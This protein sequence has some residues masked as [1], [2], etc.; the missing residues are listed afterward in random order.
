MTA[1]L[2]LIA[3]TMGDPAGIGP[4]IVVKALARREVHET[5]IPVVLGDAGVLAKARLVAGG[6]V[7]VNV[8]PTVEKAEAGA[9]N[10]V[11]Y[12]SINIDDF[13]FG[14]S[15]VDLGL[16]S[17][18]YIVKAAELAEAGRVQA[19]VTSP[20]N[21]AMLD[22]AGYAFSGHTEMLKDYTKTKHTAV[23]L[24]GDK[25]RV[26]RVTSH[27]PLKDIPCAL[28][29]E[30]VY[31]AIR[32]T[33]EALVRDLGIAEP[34][35][36]VC[37]LN[38]HAGQGGL[39]GEEEQTILVPALARAKAEGVVAV[40]P[41]PAEK[42]F[43]RARDGEFDAV[44]CMYHDQSLVPFRL[45]DPGFGV[46]ITLGLPFIR[47]SPDHG[48]AYSIAGKGYAS[49]GAMARAIRLAAELVANRRQATEAGGAPAPS[50]G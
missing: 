40:G 32:L 34:R 24:V 33:Y 35:L 7:A 1:S 13:R 22:Q 45:I 6:P 30:R 46:N 37:G 47:T 10:V 31:A 2:P 15:R 16:I 42:V 39:F 26:T 21:K 4:E 17:T 20:I 43:V 9:V 3:I 38:P 49:D 27:I 12:S 41:Y 29:E 25:L 18:F 50:A 14:E 48:T 5:C 28:T 36:A 19:I 8:V 23:M 11:S 44:V